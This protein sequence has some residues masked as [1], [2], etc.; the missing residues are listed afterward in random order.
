MGV[1]ELGVKTATWLRLT[2][3]VNGG[4][5]LKAKKFRSDAIYRRRRQTT[6][7]H[8]KLGHAAVRLHNGRRTAPIP[9]TCTKIPRAY[10]TE[11]ASACPTNLTERAAVLPQQA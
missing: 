8:M 11:V 9:A 3:S 10:P 2:Y 1:K 7:E 5:C 4:D 6:N